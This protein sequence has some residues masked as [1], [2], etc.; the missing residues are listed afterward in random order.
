MKSEKRLICPVTNQRAKP[1]PYS[2]EE[3]GV[4][5]ILDEEEEDVLL[6]HPLGWGEMTLRVVI[7]NPLI[8]EA[9]AAREVEKAEAMAQI[10]RL[11]ADEGID[12]TQR[13]LLQDHL[14]SGKAEAEV[15]TNVAL[16]IPLPEHETVTARLSY[17]V[18]GSEAVGVLVQ[19]LRE[20]GFRFTLPG[21]GE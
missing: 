8:P 1:V 7:P 11:A 3:E 18:L 15:D 17:P 9:K 16:K 21:E 19:K 13:K 6:D 12:A 20:A 4:F 5:V 2:E 10:R 14:E